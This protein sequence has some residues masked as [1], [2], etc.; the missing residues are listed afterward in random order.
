MT[1]LE[2][3]EMTAQVGKIVQEATE[4]N[5][6]VAR[7]TDIMEGALEKAGELLSSK[8]QVS[9]VILK[10]LLKCDPEH[11]GGLQLL[12]LCKHRMGENAEAVEIIQTALEL[13]P[14]CADNWNNLGLSYGGLGQYD[15]AIEAIT[16][17]MDLAPDQFLFK[18][19]LGLQYRGLGDYENAVKYLREAIAV[20]PQPQL[21]LNLGGIYG[22]MKD[23]ANAEE[24]FANSVRLDPEYAAG[25]VDLAFAYHLKGDWK[26]GFAA[27]EWRFWYYPQMKFY[28][29]AYDPEKLWDGKADVNGKRVLI[30]GEQGLGDILQF[31]RYCKQLKARGAHVIVHCPLSL[32]SVIKRIEGV[33]ETTNKDI[34]N[35]SK[36]QF[37]PYD[38]QFSMMS[39]PYLL[40]VDQLDGSPYVVPTT[41]A[42]KDYIK[43]EYKGTF[44]I[45]LIWAGSPAHPHDR[46][47]SIPLKHFRGIIETPG[48][49]AFS[50]QMDLRPRQYGVTYRNMSS[51]NADVNDP[52]SEKF[53][54]DS[55]FV[56]YC[57]GCEDLKLVDLTKMIQS[58]EDTCT[59]LAGLDMVICCDTAIA[60]LAGAMGKPVWVALPYNPDWRWTLEGS[61]TPWYDSMKL[62]RQTERDKWS[63]VFERITKELHET[64][65]PNQ[66]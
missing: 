32:D 62:F 41:L 51:D 31:S 63:D 47:R 18:N 52:C 66:Q 38:L 42:F 26:K 14:T 53:Q 57:E 37:P 34:V 29:E 40:D 55:G 46:K 19:N 13:D 64:V 54:G 35:P 36:E 20:S 43:E 58:F 9:E 2:D 28:H 22:E 8:P 30:Y 15:R 60:H 6:Q 50:L 17:A 65:L 48:V 10:Q 56:D 23:I 33:D 61:T 4:A 12:G 44:N 39:F 49:R 7:F 24:C 11:L 5:D 27:Y 1:Q 21:W 25:Y 59:I 3:K 45:G 16:K